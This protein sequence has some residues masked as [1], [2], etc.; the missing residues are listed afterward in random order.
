MLARY[1]VIAA[2]VVLCGGA[3]LYAADR[4]PSVP[5]TPQSISL[6]QARKRRVGRTVSP[7]LCDQRCD[8]RCHKT[9]DGYLTVHFFKSER[10]GEGTIVRLS[11]SHWVF[12]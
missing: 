7:Q 11:S 1:L 6:F 5:T 10:D 3:L 4:K 12:I 8:S 2:A 9:Y